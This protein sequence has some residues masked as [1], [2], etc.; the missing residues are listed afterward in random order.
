MLKDFYIWNLLHANAFN[1]INSTAK[2]DT[3][4]PMPIMTTAPMAQP[5]Y[6]PVQTAPYPVMNQSYPAQPYPPPQ[7]YAPQPAYPPP[8]GAPYP[9]SGAIPQPGAGK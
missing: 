5:G 1:E 7:G 9:V 2:P 3:A 4:Q 8:A 6:A